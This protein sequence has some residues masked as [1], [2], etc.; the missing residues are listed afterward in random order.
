M[1]HALPDEEQADDDRDRQQ[2]V[3]DAARQIDP[4]IADRLRRAA[5]EAA[6]Q[7]DGERNAGRGRHEIVH[8]QPRHLREI[9]HRR[10]GHIGLPVRVGDEAHRRVEGEALL[11]RGLT[12]RVEGQDPLQ[13]LQRIKRDEA[14]HAEE[15]H[16]DGIGDPMLV[17]RLIDAAEP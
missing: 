12:L 17:F 14:R 10:F 11:D 3:E 8:R 7:R 15:Q 9:A 16:G 13:P 6:D 1:R 2:D 5:R 4:E